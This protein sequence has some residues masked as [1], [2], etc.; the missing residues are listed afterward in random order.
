MVDEWHFFAS[1]FYFCLH[2]QMSEIEYATVLSLYLSLWVCIAFNCASMPLYVV[3]FPRSHVLTFSLSFETDSRAM[4]TRSFSLRYVFFDGELCWC[5][6]FF[7]DFCT[8]CD[9]N[10]TITAYAYIQY[11]DLRFNHTSSLTNSD[12]F[13]FVSIEKNLF[14]KKKSLSL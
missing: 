4:K 14:L 6:C 2:H 1:I 12:C 11:F 9:I 7:L 3:G 13:Q 8:H 10:Q 5:C